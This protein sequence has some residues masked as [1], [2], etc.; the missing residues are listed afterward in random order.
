M[1][2]IFEKFLEN[3]NKI[4]AKIVSEVS[5]IAVNGHAVIFIYLCL[6]RFL[7]LL[8]NIYQRF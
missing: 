1:N 8:L 6:I 4:I 5:H 3:K 2:K 7:R